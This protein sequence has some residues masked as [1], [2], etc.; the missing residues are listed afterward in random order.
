MNKSSPVWFI[1]NTWNNMSDEGGGRLSSNI[2]NIKSDGVSVFIDGYIIP[3]A[4][5]YAKYK[6]QSQTDLIITL[7]KL[8]GIEF[9]KYIK[10]AYNIIIFNQNKFYIYTDIHSIKKY[11][12]YRCNGYFIISNSLKYITDNITTSLNKE[13]AIIYCLM[14]HYVDG[15]TMFNDINYSRPASIFCF[16]DKIK[17]I[18]YWSPKKLLN[19]DKE[20]SIDDLVDLWKG[21]IYEY[22][23]YL[24]P[25]EIT[26]TLTGGNDTR[27]VLASLLNNGIKPNS[28]TFGDSKS[29]DVVVANSIANLLDLNYNNYFI[30][31]PTKEWFKEFSDLI[32]TTGNTLVNIHR[33]HRLHSIKEEMKLNPTNEMLFTGFMG[34]DYIKGI[35]YDDYITSMLMRMWKYDKRK[36]INTILKLIKHNYI[37]CPLSMLECINHRIIEL[38]YFNRAS[39]DIERELYYIYYVIGC[40]H[41]WQDS[42]IFDRHIKYVVNPFMD[43]DFLEALFSSKYSMLHKDNT[44]DGIFRKMF[45]PE[46]HIKISN[47][48]APNLSDIPYA[49]K[50]YYSNNEYMNNKLTY[51]LRRVWRYRKRMLYSQNFPLGNWFKDYVSNEFNNVDN[52]IKE[53]FNYELLKKVLM[54]NKHLT[55]EESWHI[56]TNI[57]NLSNNF[58]YFNNYE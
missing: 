54:N 16:E 39:T 56:Y 43:I 37:K 47:S 6:S 25:N 32:I 53:L 8:Y 30:N 2:P 55:T 33:A 42:Y 41:D 57:I 48:L 40:T 4:S 5:V 10:G 49:K 23:D 3:R 28:F 58:K 36:N 21:I 38:P 44:G 45:Y 17:I 51:I 13:N 19:V 24:R 1:T 20:N 18:D 11:F 26:M 22:T 31:H 35:V 14:E 15:A 27:M 34:G 50:G 12:I 52:N 46:L 7:F 9:I 29:G